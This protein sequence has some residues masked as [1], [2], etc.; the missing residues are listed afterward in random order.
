MQIEEPIKLVYIGRPKVQKN[1]LVIWKGKGGRPIV[2]HSKKMIDIRN[3]MMKCFHEQ[4]TAMGFTEPIDCHVEIFFDFYS[5]RQWEPDLDNLPAIVLDALQGKK[6]K[7]K[8][9]TIVKFAVLSDDKLLRRELS[10]KLIKGEDYAADGEP[11]TEITIRKYVPRAER[12]GD[13]AVGDPIPCERCAER[14]RTEGEV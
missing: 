3:D 10:E 14:D 8:G 9:E 2:G 4:Y 1:D 11:R 7:K 12:S 13:Y 5:T 6:A